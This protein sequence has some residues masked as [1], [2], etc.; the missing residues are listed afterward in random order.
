MACEFKI[1]ESF[2]REKTGITG[3]DDACNF[4]G[5]F[6]RRNTF[7]LMKEITVVF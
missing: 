4:I 7:I 2:E 5:K 1:R 6:S 3:Y